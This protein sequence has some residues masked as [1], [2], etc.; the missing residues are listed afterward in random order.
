MSK[1]KPT[2]PLAPW[3]LK[4]SK[5]ANPPLPDSPPPDDDCDSPPPPPP[6]YKVVHHHHWVD[7]KLRVVVE[8]D[9]QSESDD[10]WRWSSWGWHWWQASDWCGSSDATGAWFSE[11]CQGIGDD[12]DV[13]Q[14]PCQW[15]EVQID[16]VAT[17]VAE[18]DAGW[19]DHTTAAAE[20]QQSWQDAG[21]DPVDHTTAAVAVQS[22]QDTSW[23]D[24]T[25]FRDCH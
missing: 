12:D 24:Y 1:A 22:W 16:S 11:H 19:V 15:S 18:Q 3:Q 14:L 7:V 6:Q 9:W 13:A 20:A 5:V 25:A 17:S 2:P 23:V 10:S 8:R 4:S 21:W